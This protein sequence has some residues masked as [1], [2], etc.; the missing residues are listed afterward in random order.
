MRIFFD[1]EFTGLRQDTTLISIG[2]VSDDNRTFYAEFSDYKENQV[3]DWLKENVLA[4]LRFVNTYQS[5]P[6]ID[7]EHYDMKGKRSDVV[8]MLA[9]WLDQFD[10]VELWSDTLAYDWVLFCD[11]FGGAL[12]IPKNVLYIPFDI[13]TLMKVK[14]VDPDINREEFAGFVV[15]GNGRKHNA[16]HDAKMIRIC[17]NKLTSGVVPSA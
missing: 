12:S 15:D 16:L 9:Q 8:T 2:L 6:L 4:N 1:T 3:D 11:L 10:A 17:Y 7:F 13:A 14:D 5:V